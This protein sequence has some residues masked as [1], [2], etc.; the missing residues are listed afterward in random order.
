VL[1]A[2]EWLQEAIEIQIGSFCFCNFFV[3]EWQR[4]V[5]TY[6]IT[7]DEKAILIVLDFIDI[8]TFLSKN[9]N[10]IYEVN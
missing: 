8:Y 1:D 5:S 2:Q 3:P 7:S 9:Q 4:F 6:T 10:F